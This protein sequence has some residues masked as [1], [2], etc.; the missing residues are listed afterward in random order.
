MQRLVTEFPESELQLPARYWLAE[1]AFRLTNYVDAGK[2]FTS[3]SNDIGEFD[4]AWVPMVPL[5][6]AQC[7]AHEEQWAEALAIAQGIGERFPSFR[8]LYE[9]DY[10]MGRCLSMQARFVTGSVI[11]GVASVLAAYRIVGGIEHKMV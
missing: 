11:F 8:Q 3:L 5:R 7:L 6:Q 10:V 1:A 4:A 9:A 2:Q